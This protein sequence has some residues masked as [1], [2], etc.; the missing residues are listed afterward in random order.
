M[1]LT[2]NWAFELLVLG[3]SLLK[4]LHELVEDWI[5]MLMF[6]SWQV[7]QPIL[8]R[9]PSLCSL[10]K[11]LISVGWKEPSSRLI[12]C[13]SLQVTPLLIKPSVLAGEITLLV[14]E[15]C[16]T[17][18]KHIL[19]NLT[20]SQ[21]PIISHISWQSHHFASHWIP[22]LPSILLTWRKAR[23]AARWSSVDVHPW[24][25]FLFNAPWSMKL[26]AVFIPMI[27]LRSSTYIIVI[28]AIMNVV[29]M[30]AVIL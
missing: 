27:H 3:I 14:A 26:L 28:I 13:A 19:K 9:C 1:V 24:W 10:A 16:K 20:N 12:S 15:M 17:Y 18:Q 2:K 5:P 8:G 22:Q 7:K 25:S 21:C 30:M 11:I 23:P 4:L 29:P 6:H